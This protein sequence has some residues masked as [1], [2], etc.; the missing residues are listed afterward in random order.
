MQPVNLFTLFT[1]TAVRP[2]AP[3]A[4]RPG[5]SAAV[6]HAASAAVRPGAS[7]AVLVGPATDV[8][9]GAEDPALVATYR[10]CWTR[11]S[12]ASNRLQ[13]NRVQRDHLVASRR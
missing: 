13:H 10:S 2:E 9:A 6:R 1:S 8:F 4:I 3:A 7:A 11:L 12:R 5:A